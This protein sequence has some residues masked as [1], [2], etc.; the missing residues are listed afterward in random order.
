MKGAGKDGL[1][2]LHS[3]LFS[4]YYL[5]TVYLGW[6]TGWLSDYLT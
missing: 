2:T 3:R 4:Y 1:D 6:L 5:F